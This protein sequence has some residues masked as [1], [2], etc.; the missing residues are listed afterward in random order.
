MAAADTNTNAN[1]NANATA[2]PAERRRQILIM[3]GI[4]AAVVVL[5]LVL[6]YSLSGKS[7]PAK[8]APKITLMTP[9]APPPPPPPPPKFEKKPEPPKEQKEVEVKQQ[10]QKQESPPPSPEL[11]MEGAAGSGPSAF[12]SGAVTS[13][14]L[15]K[16]GKGKGGEGTVAAAN[17]L[18]NPFT[19]YVNQAS[20]EYQRYL[21]KVAA[22][23]K[24]RY[25]VE[26]HVWVASG[27]LVERFE[28]KSSTGDKDSEEALRQA[29]ASMQKL[30]QAPPPNM[31]QPIKLR[32]YTG[33]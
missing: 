17:S 28:V 26:L 30:S 20:G 13:E 27:G 19:N 6:W 10:V 32:I 1:A 15:S 21:R 4:G 16:V 22:L 11:K 5:G 29:I 9:P 3:A 7:E 23:R 2:T 25:N 24:G 12:A 18:M 14:D 8:K 33:A 31:P